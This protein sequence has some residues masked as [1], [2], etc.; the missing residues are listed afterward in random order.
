MS[1]FRKN[2]AIAILSLGAFLTLPVAQALAETDAMKAQ[3][4]ADTGFILNSSIC[5]I[6]NL[7]LTAARCD[8]PASVNS[9]R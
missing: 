5:S 7:L 8:L 3:I 6:A 1:D 2:L 9:Q 4:A